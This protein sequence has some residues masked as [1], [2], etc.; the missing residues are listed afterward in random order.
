MIQAC[1][2]VVE[3]YGV[4]KITSTTPGAVIKIN[5]KTTDSLEVIVGREVEWSVE[6]E[7]YIAQTGKVFFDKDTTI[8]IELE[9][10]RRPLNKYVAIAYQNTIGAVSDDGINWTATTLPAAHRWI[11][12]AA[13]DGKIIALAEGGQMAYTENGVDWVELPGLSSAYWAAITYGN[14]R[15]VAVAGTFMSSSNKVAYSDDG[16]NWTEIKNSNNLS[17][18]WM[19][20]TYGDGWFVAVSENGPFMC[21][22]D[23]INWLELAVDEAAWQSIAY[24]NGYFVAIAYKSTLSCWSKS[25]TTLWGNATMPLSQDW[26]TVGQLNGKFV[27]LGSRSATG[28]WMGGGNVFGSWSTMSMPSDAGWHGV[29]GGADK[30]VAVAGTT[31]EAAYSSD[32]INWTTT[33][34]PASINWYSVI[35]G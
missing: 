23:G 21:S 10:Y 24:S 9:K 31:D 4:F 33:T 5:G 18:K 2:P 28:C 22:E 11:S 34:M 26:Y 19:S 13:G 27:A 1:R 29:C 6:A 15:Y 16:I 7:G 17:K 35:Y 20:V 14:G 8:T 12:L 25:V 3:K 30:F 32:G